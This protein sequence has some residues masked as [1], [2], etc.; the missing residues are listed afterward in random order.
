[1]KKLLFSFLIMTTASAFAEKV[2]YVTLRFTQSSYTLNLWQHVKDK[3]NEFSLTIP[4]TKKFY[5]SVKVNQ[6]LRKKFKKAS[7]LISGNIGERKIIVDR[8]FVREEN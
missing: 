2:Y 8:K 4:T 7:L 3:A 1:M 5:D 6:E